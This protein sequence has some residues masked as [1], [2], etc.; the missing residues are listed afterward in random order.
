MRSLDADTVRLGP[1]IDPGALQASWSTV[2]TEEGPCRALTLSWGGPGGVHVL[3]PEDGAIP[4]A[5]IEC[6]EFADGTVWSM[7]QMVALVS[8]APEPVVAAV[9]EWPAL[10]SGNDRWRD[11]WALGDNGAS[12]P[13]SQGVFSGAELSPAQATFEAQFNN[14]IHAMAAFAPPP[15]ASFTPSS[16]TQ[17]SAFVPVLAANPF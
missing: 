9:S 2:D 10:A 8:S 5:G 17:A 15:M 3:M 14:L 6:F 13:L 7:E 1:G 12:N 16:D 4:G 11:I